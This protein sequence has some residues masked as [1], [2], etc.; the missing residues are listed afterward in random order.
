MGNEDIYM[1]AKRLLIK[2]S[3][4]VDQESGNEDRAY[5]LAKELGMVESILKWL[6]DTPE[7]IEYLKRQLEVL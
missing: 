1:L 5:R 2:I 7:N 6:P 4:K 3:S